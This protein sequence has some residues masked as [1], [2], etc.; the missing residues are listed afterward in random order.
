MRPALVGATS[1]SEFIEVTTS[2]ARQQ[3]RAMTEQT[4]EFSTLVR[5]AAADSVKPL[6]IVGL[7]GRFLGLPDHLVKAEPGCQGS[8]LFTPDY[9]DT[10]FNLEQIAISARL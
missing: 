5:K 10:L 6:T 3:W 9:L 7:P 8:G 4:M 2:H 1:P